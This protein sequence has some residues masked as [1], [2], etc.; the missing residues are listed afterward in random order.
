MQKNYLN[1]VIVFDL[2]SGCIPPNSICYCY[3]IDGE[4]FWVNFKDP[5]LGRRDLKLHRDV[6]RDHG[7][8]TV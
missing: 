4:Y 5:I 2:G 6:V 1:K 8:I 3:K 7:R